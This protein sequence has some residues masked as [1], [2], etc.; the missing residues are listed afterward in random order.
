MNLFLTPDDLMSFYG[1]THFP[2]DPRYGR[3]IF[4]AQVTA[5]QSRSRS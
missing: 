2:V 3:P 4:L 1:A 5:T